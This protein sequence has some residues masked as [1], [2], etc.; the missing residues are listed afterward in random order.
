[1][2]QRFRYA[3]GSPNMANLLLIDDD[4]D[5]LPDQIAHV[6]PSPVFAGP[7][8]SGRMSLSWTCVCPTSPGWTC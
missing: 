7:L 3:Q 2:T 1:M 5:L 8:Q 4:P 6:F